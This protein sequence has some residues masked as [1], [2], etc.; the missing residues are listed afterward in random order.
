MKHF[1][2]GGAVL[3]IRSMTGYRPALS[4]LMFLGLSESKSYS[5]LWK[6]SS[7][8]AIWVWGTQMLER[9]KRKCQR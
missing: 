4:M 3:E 8:M 5:L 9:R 6:T 2:V 1:A 7:Q